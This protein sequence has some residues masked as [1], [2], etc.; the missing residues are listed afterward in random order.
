MADS[1]TRLYVACLLA[2]L[3]VCM[4]VLASLEGMSVCFLNCCRNHVLIPRAKAGFHKEAASSS[5][6]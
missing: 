6:R 3:H 4:Y 5:A 1:F 2:R